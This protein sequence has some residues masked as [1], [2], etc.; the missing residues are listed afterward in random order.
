MTNR[1]IKTE[2][3]YTNALSSIEQLIDAEPGTEEMDRLELLTIL[4]EMYEKQ[5]FPIS[6]PDPIDAIK[7]RM[8]QLGL[9][10]KD[11]I[12][13]IGSKSKVS[14]VLSRKRSLTLAMMRS[15]NRWLGISAEL[16][17]K[18]PGANFPEEMEGL[19]WEKFP[20]IE[21]VKRNWISSCSDV[22]GKAEELMRAFVQEACG[23]EGIPRVF[24]R[25]GLR[26][27]Y[28]HRMD[29]YA[30]TAWCL[31]VMFLAGKSPL[32]SKYVEGS[33]DISVM[34]EVARLSNFKE[35]PLLA[36]E[37]LE[38][39]GIHLIVE[40][41]LPKTYL[42]GVALL[43]KNTPIIGLTLRHDRTDNFW[44]CL[45]HELAHVSKHLSDSDGV[46]VDDLDLR[47]E[48]SDQ[49]NLIEKEADEMTRDG[50]IPNEIWNNNPLGQNPSYVDILPFAA[51]LKI[52]PAI[53]V[54]RV[55]FEQKDYRILSR[56]VGSN[57]VRK[58]FWAKPN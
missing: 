40:S 8:D 57:E 58:L 16:L 22:N 23:S 31:R 14:E 5:Q 55:R 29:H 24:C 6:H 7:F 46:I 30:L 49:E 20:I 34:R 15:L 13:Y 21:M 48:E 35:G 38:N 3:D 25:N 37:Y 42:D 2:I 39:L 45:L 33:I 51:K 11:L 50:L 18:E 36:K 52:N 32:S 28:N 19:E 53:V 10:Q 27:R 47:N 1:L 12:P 43:L 41:H 54:G 26:G 17:L 56:Y 9:R 44:F 4:V